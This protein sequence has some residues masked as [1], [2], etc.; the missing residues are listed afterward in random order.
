MRTKVKKRNPEI[1]LR[2]GKPAA[3]ILDIEEYQELLERLEDVEDLKMLERMRKKPLRFRKL[4]DF[5][6]EYKPS[7]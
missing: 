3:I 2:D 4:E 6:K 5:L 7:V 1:I